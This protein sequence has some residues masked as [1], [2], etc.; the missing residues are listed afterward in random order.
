MRTG[1]TGLC[2]GH[3]SLAEGLSKK[4]L[5]INLIFYRSIRRYEKRVKVRV[6]QLP[7]RGE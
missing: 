3:S 1:R 5:E 6:V 4:T 2:A 7:I